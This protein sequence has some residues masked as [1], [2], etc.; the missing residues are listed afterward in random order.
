MTTTSF[1]TALKRA[2]ARRGLSQ[3]GAGVYLADALLAPLRAHGLPPAEAGSIT[4]SL[5]N[6][7][8]GRYEPPPLLQGLVLQ[9]LEG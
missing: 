1:A 4:R 7:E 3:A 8:T 9:A 2:R 6:W 5:Q